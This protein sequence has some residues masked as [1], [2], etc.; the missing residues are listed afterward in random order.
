MSNDTDSG[1]SLRTAYL[2][3]FEF[4]RTFCERGHSTE[5][6]SL[7]GAMSLLTD[8]GSADPAMLRDFER[9]VREVLRREASGGY[10]SAHFDV[11]PPER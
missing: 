2:A 6:E 5:I 4:L 7:L 10:D 11:R 9:S 8:G 3:M 1:L